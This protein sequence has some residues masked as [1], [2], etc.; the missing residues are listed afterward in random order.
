MH[1][2]E[3][4][5]RRNDLLQKAVSLDLNEL[6]HIKYTAADV[7][8]TSKIDKNNNE[9]PTT[10][11]Q[12][13]HFDV[14]LLPPPN[15]WIKLEEGKSANGLCYNLDNHQIFVLIVHECYLTFGI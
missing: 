11:D 7:A 5:G 6:F 10:V 12:L 3:D 8:Y 2:N 1:R 14:R 9:T 13:K 4:G 15:V